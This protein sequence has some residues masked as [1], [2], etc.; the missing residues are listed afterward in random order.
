MDMASNLDSDPKD[1]WA[2]GCWVGFDDAYVAGYNNVSGVKEPYGTAAFVAA[3]R[4]AFSTG[5]GYDLGRKAKNRGALSSRYQSNESAAVINAAMAGCRS[6][7]EDWIKKNPQGEFNEAQAQLHRE[8]AEFHSKWNAFYYSIEVGVLESG[9]AEI[10]RI[11]AYH[12]DLMGYIHRYEAMGFKASYVP[13]APP[14]P[15]PDP[16][17]TVT[18]D[19]GKAAAVV[20]IG[21]VG[22]FGLKLYLENRKR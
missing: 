4:H 6:G 21:A 18:T 11:R 1:E 5:P 20:A 13:P 9:D 10:E 3:Y 19:I 8:F 2:D 17:G 14:V 15:D 16:L 7:Y 12:K 22:Y